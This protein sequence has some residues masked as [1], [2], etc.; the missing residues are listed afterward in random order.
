MPTENLPAAISTLQRLREIRAIGIA[1]LLEGPRRL[2]L[3]DY[4]GELNRLR[5]KGHKVARTEAKIALLVAMRERPSQVVRALKVLRAMCVEKKLE[6]RFE[7]FEALVAQSLG[8]LRLTNHS[9]RSENFGKMSHDPIWERV[10]SHLSALSDAGYEAF[11]NSGTLLGVVRDA[12]LID[13][14]DDIDLAVILKAVTCA[15]AVEEW[16]QLRDKLRADGILDEEATLNGSFFKLLPIDNIQIDLFPAWVEQGR[17]YLFPHT[18]GEL[19]AADVLPLKTCNI[20]QNP[21]PADP[22]KMLAVNYG[23]GWRD[24][25]PYFKFPWGAAKTKFKD[26]L[27]GVNA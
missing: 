17:F 12:R 27:S 24:P 1:A 18:F 2:N 5:V 9:Y 6:D 15:E 7:R 13:H 22:E 8:D 11:L 10:S 20:T 21:I 25:D 3:W 19:S 14:D 16:L 26:F 23:E 4:V